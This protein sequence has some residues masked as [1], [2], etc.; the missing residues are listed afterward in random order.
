MISSLYSGRIIISSALLL[1]LVLAGI[2]IHRA[3]KPYNSFIFSIH[4]LFTV[5]MVIIMVTVVVNFFRV[6]DGTVIHYVATAAAGVALTG[7]LISGAM[8]SLDRHQ[9]TML[10]MHRISTALFLVS[11]PLLAWLIITNT[12]NILHQ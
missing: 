7:L 2:V 4:K 3:G 6:T 8:M 10:L 12:L 5:A 9:E 1:L 11:Y